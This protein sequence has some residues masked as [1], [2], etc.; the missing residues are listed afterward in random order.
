MEWLMIK[1]QRLNSLLAWM[2]LGLALTS[3]S[4]S[5]LGYNYLSGLT[6]GLCLAIVINL[7][8]V[9]LMEF[10]FRAVQRRMSRN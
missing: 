10:A 9:D 3:T 4:L 5:N 2:G 7:Y 6:M 8:A 1:Q